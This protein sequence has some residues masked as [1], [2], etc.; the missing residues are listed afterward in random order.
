MYCTTEPQDVPESL[1]MSLMWSPTPQKPT[2]QDLQLSWLTG[3]HELMTL[4]SPRTMCCCWSTLLLLCTMLVS[5]KGGISITVWLGDHALSFGNGLSGSATP[6]STPP[7]KN[8]ILFIFHIFILAFLQEVQ[9]REN[10]NLNHCNLFPRTEPF[11][12]SPSLPCWW[13]PF[14]FK[15]I[16]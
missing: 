11:P 16:L 9:G 4:F 1:P 13:N 14:V 5:H 7:L 10:M 3:T 12:F 15:T 2:F 6:A 8:S